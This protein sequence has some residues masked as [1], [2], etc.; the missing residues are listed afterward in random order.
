MSERTPNVVVVSAPSGA[1]K[2]TVLGRI[3]EE[4]PGIRFSVSHTTRKP[5]EGETDGVHYHFVNKKAFEELKAGGR[6]LEWANVH[7][8]LYGTS[9]AEYE[10]ARSEGV[11]LLLDVDV[12]GAAQVRVKIPDAVSIFVLPPSFEA[13]ERRL[14][15]RGSESETLVARRLKAA[16][17]E[18]SLYG[19]YDYTLINDDLDRCVESLKCVIRAARCRTRRMDGE[20]S[21][22]L[23]TFRKK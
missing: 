16:A 18:A 2:S 21:R 20:A 10:R 5:R 3:L 1:G 17:E 9:H 15:G 7:D 22:I 8:H 23:E 14:R 4:L 12:Q 19:E 11:D 13:L 6:M